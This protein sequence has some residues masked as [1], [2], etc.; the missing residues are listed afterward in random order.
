[1]SVF[2]EEIDT[3]ESTWH[4]VLGPL[5]YGMWWALGA[6][7]A[8]LALFLSATSYLGHKYGNQPEVKN[9]SFYDPWIDVMASFCQQG[10]NRSPNISCILY[11]NDPC[12]KQTQQNSNPIY[13]N[14]SEN[15]CMWLIMP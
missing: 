1:M 7:M 15:K 5:S 14:R 12:S 2:I 10:K 3:D 8:M 9:Y 6:A 13:D 4:Y 11:K